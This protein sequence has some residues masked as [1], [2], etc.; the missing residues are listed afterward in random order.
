MNAV[1]AV[2]DHRMTSHRRFPIAAST[3]TIAAVVSTADATG[4]ETRLWA[5]VLTLAGDDDTRRCAVLRELFWR[6]LT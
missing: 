4:A 6:T 3:D 5:P 2:I 1:I